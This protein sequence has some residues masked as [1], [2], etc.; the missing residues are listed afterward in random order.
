MKANEKVEID[1][2]ELTIQEQLAAEAQILSDVFELSDMESIDLILSGE[3][4]QIHFEG[5]NRGLIAVIC[6]YD[7]HRQY[8]SVITS[9]KH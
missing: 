4:Q 9:Y 8:L 7:A 2:V 5:L 6:Y 1:G 3:S